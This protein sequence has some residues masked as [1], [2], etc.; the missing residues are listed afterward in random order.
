M[1]TFLNGL[2]VANNFARTENG[3]ITHKSTMSGLMDMFAMGAAY[4]SRS[5]EDCILL[6]KNAYL[7]DPTYALKCLFYISDCRGGQG[8]RRFFRVCAKWLASYDTEAMRRNLIHI[9]EYR[10]WDD[11]FIFIGTPLEKDALAIVK[12]Q[13]ALDVQCKTPSLLGKWM[14][15][16]NTSSSKTRKTALAVRK[17]LGMTPRQYRKTLSVLRARINVLERLMSEGRW[18]EIEFDKIPSKAGLKYKNAFARH[19]IERMK[20]EKNVQSYE[21]FAKD[22]TKTVNAKTLYPYEVV[23]KAVEVMGG[24]SGRIAS[25][26][27]T[28]RLMVNK[29]WANLADYFNGASLNALAVVD[30]S[31]SMNGHDAAAPINVAIS[32]GLYCAE[33]AKG[34]FAGHYISFSSRPQ[35]IKTDGVDFCD[36]VHRIYRTNLCENTDIEATFDMLLNT[37]IQN[38]CSQDDLPQNIIVISDQEFDAARGARSYWGYSNNSKNVRTL[39]EDIEAKWQA[40]GYKM[41]NLV[42][43]NVAARNNNIPME[44]KDGVSFVS[45]MSPVIFEQI[46]KNKTAYDLVFDKL[47]SERYALIH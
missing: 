21:D 30:T 2:Q 13:L 35:L 38:R 23:D 19:D 45:G 8:E 47:N 39:M 14:P 32:L 9:P 34:P 4:R 25:M 33:K 42:F 28:D 27:N 24:Y 1:N 12:H 11:L 22:T 29:Y 20:S 46:M 41:P 36:K 16:E 7:E 5:E 3:A 26:D 6:F 31:G 44:I 43:W 10:R 40:M 17:Y 15:S 18:D 37:A